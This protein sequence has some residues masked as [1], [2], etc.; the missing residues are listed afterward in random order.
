MHNNRINAGTVVQNIRKFRQA[1]SRWSC[2]LATLFGIWSMESSGREETEQSLDVVKFTQ[3]N[4]NLAQL[5]KLGGPR[6]PIYSP[7]LV[8]S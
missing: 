1:F 3:N 7:F 8:Q 5:E 4:N 6:G 2:P